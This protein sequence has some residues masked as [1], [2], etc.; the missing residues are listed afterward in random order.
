MPETNDLVYRTV[1][2]LK[3]TQMPRELAEKMLE[4]YP[5]EWIEWS[6]N[7]KAKVG[8]KWKTN[9]SPYVSGARVLVHLNGILGPGNWHF[10]IKDVQ[11]NYVEAAAIDG[12]HIPA[13][14]LGVPL[15]IGLVGCFSAA[16]F[17][18]VCD[19]GEDYA[20][21]GNLDPDDWKAGKA[22]KKGASLKNAETD[23][24]KRS[25][26]NYGLGLYMWLTPPM[27]VDDYYDI[28]ASFTQKVQEI[29]QKIKKYVLKEVYGE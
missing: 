26:R 3:E 23:A 6:N 17:A 15:Y 24:I 22:L 14:M 11:S 10:A 19:V 27:Y 8:K 28:P 13:H 16:G 21:W 5:D 1:Q 9:V 7:G 29:G 2:Q 25:V 18:T 12:K 20:T 4:P